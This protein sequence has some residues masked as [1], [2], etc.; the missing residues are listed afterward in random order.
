MFYFLLILLLK[1]WA[2]PGRFLGRKCLQFSSKL[3][4]SNKATLIHFLFDFSNETFFS[5]I[6]RWL[7]IHCLNQIDW[8]FDCFTRWEGVIE[9]FIREIIEKTILSIAVDQNTLWISAVFVLSLN[10]YNINL[11]GVHLLHSVALCLHR[12]CAICPQWMTDRI[13]YPYNFLCFIL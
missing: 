11:I 5:I 7:I 4:H 2:S 6:K 10:L 1:V 3:N 12:F 13:H 8:L 9:L